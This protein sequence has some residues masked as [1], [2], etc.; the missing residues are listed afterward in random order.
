MAK[1]EKVEEVETEEEQPEE[2]N[3]IKY[4]TVRSSV[5]DISPNM[6]EKWLRIGGRN[7]HLSSRLAHFLGDEIETDKWLLNG[8]PI[9]FSSTGHLMDGQHRLQAIVNT[10]RTVK[11]L[12]VWGI[13]PAAFATMDVGRKRSA[14]QVL[15]MEGYMCTTLL[16]AT[17]GLLDRIEHGPLALRH[18]SRT[19]KLSPLYTLALCHKRPQVQASAIYVAARKSVSVGA[20]SVAVPT[21][22]HYQGMKV[23]GAQYM[24]TFFDCFSQY[25]G[26][27]HHPVTTLRKRM[28]HLRQTKSRASQGRIYSWWTQVFNHYVGGE[29]MSRLNE[30]D[31]QSNE[32]PQI[33]DPNG[34][35]V[36]VG[37]KRI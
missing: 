23:W 14:S 18:A 7:R 13:E 24:D 25:P 1:A 10:G 11:S 20:G 19:M 36:I 12:V 26:P 15:S 22:I 6:A 37:K 2:S 27:K 35:Y 17:H 32:V 33:V 29:A 8:Q 31:W 16:A 9:I 3:V 34:N 28:E 30:W 4:A 5:K 21:A